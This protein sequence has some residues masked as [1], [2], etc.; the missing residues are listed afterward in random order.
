[1]SESKRGSPFSSELGHPQ[2]RGYLP[3]ELAQ[4]CSEQGVMTDVATPRRDL[5]GDRRAPKVV[6]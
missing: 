5:R 3:E 2:R 4:L 1:M 6:R